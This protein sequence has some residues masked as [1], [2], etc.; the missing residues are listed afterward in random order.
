MEVGGGRGDAEVVTAQADR[1]V[2]GSDLVLHLVV[3]QAEDS[4]PDTLGTLVT[5]GSHALL[6]FPGAR[7]GLRL[8]AHPQ[9]TRLVHNHGRAALILGL[10]PLAQSADAPRVDAY[11]DAALARGRL[12]FGFACRTSRTA[13]T[14]HP[15]CTAPL[16]FRRGNRHGSLRAR[17]AGRLLHQARQPPTQPFPR[18]PRPS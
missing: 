11:L 16:T 7:W 8:P 4:V 3:A 1:H 10:D 6:R 18:R 12:L 15:P 9:W 17:Q 2:D 14:T 13:R 5:Y